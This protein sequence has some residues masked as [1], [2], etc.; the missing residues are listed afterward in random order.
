MKA[1]AAQGAARLRLTAEG[2]QLLGDDGGDALGA[3]QDVEEVGDLFHHLLVLADDLVLLQAGQALQAHLQDF[4]GLGFRQAVQPV[5]AHA[6]F[7]LQAVGAVVIGIDHATVLARAG[8]HLAHQ[9]AVPGPAHQ[10]DL[11]DRGRRRIADDRDEVV[12]VGQRN[13]QALQH[14][15]AL[16]GLAQIEDRAAGHD[17]A[18]VRPLVAERREREEREREIKHAERMSE[19]TTL[20]RGLTQELRDVRSDRPNGAINVPSCKFLPTSA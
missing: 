17:L 6:E 3:G 2:R 5:L 9:L 14:M 13:G 7:A 10:F 20:V 19:L 15:A 12:D 8:E 4:L 16:A 18:A 11:R 1:P